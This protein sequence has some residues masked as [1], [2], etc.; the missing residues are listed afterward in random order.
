MTDRKWSYILLMA[1]YVLMSTAAY[2]QQYSLKALGVGLHGGEDPRI[3]NS[4]Q[5]V[6]ALANGSFLYSGGTVA[7]L[8]A[9]FEASYINNMGVIGMSASASAH[10]F[11]SGPPYTS[12]VDLGTL[13]GCGPGESIVTGLN[14]SGVAVGI[15]N[16]PTSCPQPFIFSNGHLTALGGTNSGYERL[17]INNSNQIVGAFINSAGWTRA[18]ELI[19]GVLTDIDPSNATVYGSEA[20]DINDAGEFVVNTNEAY[21]TKQLGPPTFKKITYVCSGPNWY[22][23]VY[24]GSTVT[25]LPGLGSSGAMATAIDFWGDVVGYSQTAAGVLHGFVNLYGAT[26]D[27]NSHPL[28]NGAGWTIQWAFDINDNGQ[29]LALGNDSTG[30]QDIVILTPYIVKQPPPVTIT[31]NH[32]SVQNGA[33]GGSASV[34]TVSL[35]SGAPFGG[36]VVYLSSSNPLVTVPAKIR[37]APKSTTA[38]FTIT[39]TAPSASDGVTIFATTGV[40]TK[41]STFTISGKA[42]D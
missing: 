12:Q 14:D 23:A 25:A 4:G 38:S 7:P 17:A 1:G 16:A 41:A 18:G 39:S 37:V 34:G 31:V 40:S 9:A 29:I 5:V 19:N 2:A 3:N 11:L 32:A 10:V 26:F 15:T 36:T 30:K 8:P 22:P 27:L 35:S 13:P 20:V 33:A 28:I 6:G 21:C 24:S 42:A